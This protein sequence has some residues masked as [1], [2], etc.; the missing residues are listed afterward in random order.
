[1]LDSDAHAGDSFIHS[2]HVVSDAVMQLAL[3]STDLMD[4]SLGDL[5]IVRLMSTNVLGQMHK[6]TN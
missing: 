5:D 6:D 2:Y 4:S 1:M 3:R